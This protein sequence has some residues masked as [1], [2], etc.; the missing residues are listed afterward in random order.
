MQYY[1]KTCIKNCIMIAFIGSFA[2]SILTCGEGNKFSIRRYYKKSDFVPT[3]ELFGGRSFLHSDILQQKNEK[4]VAVLASNPDKVVGVIVYRDV[5]G[6]G[7]PNPDK[8]FIDAVV[9]DTSWERRGIARQ[10]M[11]Y[12]IGQSIWRTAS[13][14]IPIEVQ[15][16]SVGNTEGF[17]D[18]LGFRRKEKSDAG[19][20]SAQDAVSQYIMNIG[21]DRTIPFS[22]QKLS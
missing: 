11:H 22:A 10:L 20:S 18:K 14:E 15:L 6:G 16:I 12:V 21:E 8:L 1:I 9:V 5:E 4:R 19:F 7:H 3:V 17:Y 2:P 13:P